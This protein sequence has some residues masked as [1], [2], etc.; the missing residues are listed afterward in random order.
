MRLVLVDD[1]ASFRD[2]MRALLGTVE[3]VEIVGEA[4]SGEE[5]VGVVLGARPDLVFMDIRMPGVDGIE[6]TRRINAQSPGTRIL[7]LTT[8]DEDELVASAVAAGAIGYLL[9]GTPLDDILDIARLALRGY[10]TFGRGLGVKPAAKHDS[11]NPPRLPELSERERR[12]WQLIGEG[13]TNREVALR[14]HLTEGTIKNYVSALL[15]V[16]G[17]RHRTQAA[18]LWRTMQ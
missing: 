1:Q 10:S 9:K 7:V 13:L 3:G 14:L 18:L 6:A 17:V 8:F 16:L 12:V 4:A 5:A 15:G 11:P 2:G